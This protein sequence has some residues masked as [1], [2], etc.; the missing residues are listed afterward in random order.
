MIYSRTEKYIIDRVNKD[1]IKNLNT[2]KPSINDI[3]Y[4]QRYDYLNDG[5]S[6]KKSIDLRHWIHLSKNISCKFVHEN[7]IETFDSTIADEV[8]EIIETY[9]IDPSQFYFLLADENHCNFLKTELA[10]RSIFGCNFEFYNA[11]LHRVELPQLPTTS[12]VTHKF[13]I[14]SRNYNVWRL[15]LFL[16]LQRQD[17]LT[18]CLYSFHNIKPYNEINNVIDKDTI[19]QDAFGEITKP[20]NKW[21]KGIPYNL[22]PSDNVKNKYSDYSYDA[23]L[24]SNINILIETHFRPVTSKS[25]CAHITEKTYKNIICKKPFIVFSTSGWIKD[26]QKLG[27]RSF[28]PFIDERYDKITDDYQRLLAIAAEVKRLNSLSKED[29]LKL[30]NY[31]QE[32]VDYNYNLFL[33]RKKHTWSNAFKFLN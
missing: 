19:R 21:I 13:S 20:V 8:K 3:F 15:N 28:S 16:E 10:T 22:S 17:L 24:R 1:L 5:I 18:D 32:V 26:F 27:Y 14:L 2:W 7:C 29:F 23:I 9:K 31:C 30:V 33:E 11:L 6:I 12:E 25:Y 4:H